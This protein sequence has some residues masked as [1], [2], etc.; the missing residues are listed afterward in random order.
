MRIA[1]RK[2][3][4]DIESPRVSGSG[5]VRL[6]DGIDVFQIPRIDGRVYDEYGTLVC[7]LINQIKDIQISR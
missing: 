3:D 6:C 2:F 4:T 7:G 5:A 1:C